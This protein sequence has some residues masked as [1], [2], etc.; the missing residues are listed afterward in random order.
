MNSITVSLQYLPFDVLGL[1]A[2][3]LK[4]SEVDI[5]QRVCKAWHIALQ[6]TSLWFNILREANPLEAARVKKTEIRNSLTMKKIALLFVYNGFPNDYDGPP[7]DSRWLVWFMSIYFRADGQLRKVFLKLYGET[8]IRE[9]INTREWVI[10]LSADRR[11]PSSLPKEINYLNEKDFTVPLEKILIESKAPPP[12]YNELAHKLIACLRDPE[13]SLKLLKCLQR[14]GANLRGQN[15]EGRTLLHT[16]LDGR[17]WRSKNYFPIVKWLLEQGVD[18]N[19]PDYEG[20][21]PGM[22]DCVR[23]SVNYRWA[24]GWIQGTR[25]VNKLKRKRLRLY[26][27]REEEL[28]DAVRTGRSAVL[29]RAK[30]SEISGYIPADPYE[31]WP[32]MEALLWGNLDCAKIIAQRLD[33]CTLFKFEY[34]NHRF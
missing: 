25:M 13:R 22:S 33:D 21:L 5:C 26:S 8:L 17:G 16:A 6:N 34:A 27:S 14:T 23:W 29:K 3:Q 32:L 28:I 12:Y 7:N 19:I 4:P 20:E 1:I 2:S 15:R 18:P 24:Q 31:C 30:L 10:W 9:F 11:R